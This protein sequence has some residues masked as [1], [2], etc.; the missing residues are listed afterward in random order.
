MWKIIGTKPKIKNPVAGEVVIA[1][2]RAGFT[3]IEIIVAIAVIAL[4][5]MVISSGIAAFRESAAIDQAL[6]EAFEL[7][8]EARSKTLGSESA[9]SF[10]VHFT[11][12]SV[13]LFKSWTYTAGDPANLVITLPA[14]VEINAIVLSTT[15]AN[16]V[17]ERLSGAAAATGTIRFI[18]KRSA[19]TK[20]IEILSSGAFRKL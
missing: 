14:I 13:T 17:F 4:L 7:L 20:Q 18:G 9:S 19:K 11:S 5:A 10:G 15:T 6:D 8:R 16:V 3:L 1:P 2:E 12:S